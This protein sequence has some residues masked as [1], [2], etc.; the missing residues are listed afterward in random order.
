M[1]A[2]GY[3]DG[4]TR[5][6]D[7]NNGKQIH[8]L[9]S[10]SPSF[11]S[12][13]CVSW[14]DNHSHQINTNVSP[15]TKTAEC[16]PEALFDLDISSMLPRLSVLPGSSG[17][18]SSF[19]SKTTLDALINA[20]T[21][22]GEGSHLDVL[23]IGD[24]SGKVLL[25]VFDSFL[26]GTMELS[27]LSHQLKPRTKLLRHTASSNLATQA[28]LLHEPTSNKLLFS[29]MDILFIQQFGQYLFQLASTSTRVQALLRY[30]TETISAMQ[31]EFKTMN[32]LSK[33]FV[34]IIAEDADNAGSEVGLEF[35]E[36]LVTGLPSP[37]LKEWL[38]DVLQ[39]RGQKRWEK[40]SMSGYENLRRLA[41]EHLLPT[42]ERLTVLFCRLRGLARW[43][44][45]GSPLGLEPDDFTRCLDVVSAITLFTHEFIINLNRELDLYGAFT[46]WLRHALDQLSTVINIEDKPVEEP[47][48]DTLK[49]A[50]F[51]GKYLRQSGL[52]SFFG[53]GNTSPLTEYKGRGESIQDLYSDTT[54]RPPGFGE[55]AKFLDDLSKSV[56]SKPQQA[57]R[58]QLRLGKPLFM[59]AG[60]IKLQD[61]RIV[62]Q[63]KGNSS[64]YVV[65]YPDENRYNS[66]KFAIFKLLCQPY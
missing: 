11:G 25:N 54:K 58:Q 49:V 45:K 37:V 14:V 28:L 61:I 18:E 55:L 22:G 9:S 2:L 19:T 46:G 44:E 23:F 39:E 12:V 27:K 66:R 36:F 8:K 4:S 56:F 21:K 24:D 48:V 60:N 30:M 52:E 3:S 34:N 5:I 40:S 20:V 10:E 15:E 51:V 42:C 53:E 63:D 38:L 16:T 59:H 31:T 57:M 50:E 43:K 64:A 41:H 1:L 62:D 32:D 29:T 33:R 65:L 13:T 26:I 6:Y 47:A 7:V 35:F 17:P